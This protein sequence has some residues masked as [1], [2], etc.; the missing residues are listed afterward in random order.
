MRIARNRRVWLGS[1]MIGLLVG[2]FILF[3]VFTDSKDIQEGV[4][5]GEE[6][7]KAKAQNLELQAIQYSQPITLLNTEYKMI[8]IDQKN[9]EIPKT[10]LDAARSA[11]DYRHGVTI[12]IILFNKD[13]NDYRLILD[14]IACIKSIHAP[15]GKMDSLQTVILY[16]IAFHDSNLD[17]LINNNDEGD[18][19]ISDLDGKNFQKIAPDSLT[20][21]NFHFTAD[22]RAIY[23]QCLR[24]ERDNSVPREHWH[25]QSGYY[26]IGFQKFTLNTEMNELIQKAKALLVN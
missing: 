18:L 16:D 5:V 11:N 20:V 10:V 9:Y 19:Y 6:K 7:A 2:L 13:K 14:H 23:L 22:R 12:N 3:Y 17:G 21:E 25:Q 4:I 26:D 1:G 24:I 15:R 8:M